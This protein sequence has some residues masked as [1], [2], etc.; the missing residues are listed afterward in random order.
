MPPR[1]TRLTLPLPGAALASQVDVYFAHMA[2]PW[3]RA[4]G[5]SIDIELGGQEVINIELDSLDANADDVVEVLR[6]GQPRVGFWTR[7][8]GEYLQT[9]NIDAAEKIALAAVDS[10]CRVCLCLPARRQ[11]NRPDRPS[12][13]RSVRRQRRGR[14]PAARVRPPRKHPALARA[15][16]PEAQARQCPCVSPQSIPRARS[17]VHAGQDVLTEKTRDEYM[18][19]ATV[20]LNQCDKILSEEGGDQATKELLML[21]RGASRVRPRICLCVC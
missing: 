7:L 1:L 5:R 9:G 14:V 13:A 2:L 20:Y 12:R 19:D 18:R 3:T 8:A 17:R 6:E 16:R 15:Q 21:T 11:D 4:P 10:A